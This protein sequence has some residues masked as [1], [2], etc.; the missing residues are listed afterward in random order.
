[1]KDRD[2]KAMVPKAMV[3]KAMVLTHRRRKHI[4]TGSTAFM[5]GRIFG[6]KTGFHPR[7]RE[8]GLFS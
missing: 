5:R 7:V 4:P 1:L 8:G 3:P 2:S 6:R